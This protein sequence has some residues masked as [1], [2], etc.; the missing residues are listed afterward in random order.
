MKENCGNK[1]VMKRNSTRDNKGEQRVN[2]GK[3]EK[4]RWIPR[5]RSPQSVV[6]PWIDLYKTVKQVSCPRTEDDRAFKAW[7][8]C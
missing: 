5:V 4:G 1:K 6:Q 7:L 8:G 2:R 3:D